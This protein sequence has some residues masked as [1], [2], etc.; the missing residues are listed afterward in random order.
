MLESFG[1]KFQ[2]RFAIGFGD[3]SDIVFAPLE[4]NLRILIYIV[5]IAYQKGICCRV[6]TNT[7]GNVFIT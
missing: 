6:I 7:I 4:L 5:S 2:I 1:G 3:K